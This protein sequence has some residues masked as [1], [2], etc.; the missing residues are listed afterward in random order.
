MEPI[1]TKGIDT[2]NLTSID[3]YEKELGGYQALKKR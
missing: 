1:L 2:P 3:V